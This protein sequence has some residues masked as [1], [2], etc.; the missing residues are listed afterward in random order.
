MLIDFSEIK[1]KEE[2][3]FE[4]EA[5]NCKGLL[6]QYFISRNDWKGDLHE[7]TRDWFFK[8][9]LPWGTNMETTEERVYV[10][11]APAGFGKTYI[12]E[13]L[14]RRYG[15]S[16][17]VAHYFFQYDFDQRNDPKKMLLSLS[18]QMARKMEPYRRLLEQVLVKKNVTEHRLQSDYNI[19]DIFEDFLVTPLR[20]MTRDVTRSYVIVLDALDECRDDKTNGKNEIISCIKKYFLRLPSW[21][22]VFVT[23]R[24]EYPL[25]GQLQRFHPRRIAPGRDENNRKDLLLF[26]EHVLD[27]C[28]FIGNKTIRQ[29]ALELLWKKS[30]GIFM[31]A[32]FL[33]S[34]TST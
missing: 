12:A 32:R 15:E 22:K 5:P 27:S 11:A 8:E 18:Y 29:K 25:I 21:I 33:A 23:T 10:L 17:V 2:E 13:E 3:L 7:G 34:Q 28:D 24:P 26:F 19:N 9:F 31:V 6:G 30:E 16:V 1:R 4:R 14:V 20:T